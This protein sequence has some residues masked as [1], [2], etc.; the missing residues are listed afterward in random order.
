MNKSTPTPILTKDISRKTFI[1][2]AILTG[3][4]QIESS[5]QGEYYFSG[6]NTIHGVVRSGAID[7][8]CRT[9]TPNTDIDI[10]LL[11]IG[12]SEPIQIQI[13]LELAHQNTIGKVEV[14]SIGGSGGNI[15][16]S[17]E[18][19]AISGVSETRLSI[20]QENLLLSPSARI[21]GI[22]SLRVA[23]DGVQ[24]AHSAT[25][26]RISPDDLTYLQSRGLS[27]ILARDLILAG[28]VQTLFSDL[29][30]EEISDIL[31]G[32]QYV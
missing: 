16:I 18:G 19:S 15:A 10:R 25:F 29:S 2:G 4:W 32:I 8:I 6:K 17:L 27:E 21:R 26:S 5:T 22:P 7:I 14:L 3:D 1:P 28:K 20:H 30:Q 31:S 23:T 9:N 12:Q 24:A 13:L 11:V